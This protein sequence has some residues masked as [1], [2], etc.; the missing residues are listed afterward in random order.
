MRGGAVRGGAAR[1]CDAVR[2]CTLRGCAVRGCT[3]RAVPCMLRL[4]VVVLPPLAVAQPQPPHLFV[5][6]V[7][8]QLDR[9]EL[10]C[11]Y[12]AD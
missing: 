5:T 12:G 7:N 8:E 10:L 9:L 11:H 3:V 2:G 6:L 4:H 1:G